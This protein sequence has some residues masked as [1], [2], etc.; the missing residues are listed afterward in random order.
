MSKLRVH[1]SFLNDRRKLDGQVA[2]RPLTLSRCHL[3]R[4]LFQVMHLVA[5]LRVKQ[6][7]LSPV[8]LRDHDV[9]L[10]GGRL[11]QQGRAKQ[12][13]TADESVRK[14]KRRTT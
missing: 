9:A 14:A 10:L 2:Q 5:S 8:K 13:Y 1:E 6:L 11:L 4:S 7:K 12:S 3:C